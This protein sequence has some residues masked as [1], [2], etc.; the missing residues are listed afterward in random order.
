MW[1]LVHPAVFLIQL[2]TKG[3]ENKLRAY[4]MSYISSF[5]WCMPRT[6]MCCFPLQCRK[7]NLILVASLYQHVSHAKNCKITTAAGQ[8][9]PS[10][11]LSLWLTSLSCV[12]WTCSPCGTWAMW[13]WP[14]GIHERRERNTRSISQNQWNTIGSKQLNSSDTEEVNASCFR[15][16]AAPTLLQHSISSTDGIAEPWVVHD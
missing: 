8:V 4:A 14:C 12:I 7:F 6:G 2:E 5:Q 3:G 11:P 10:W 1:S 15:I 13:R 9:L 16:L